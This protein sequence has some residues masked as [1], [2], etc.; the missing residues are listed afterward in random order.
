MEHEHVANLG[1]LPRQHADYQACLPEHEHKR[2]QRDDT[3]TREAR[4]VDAR[5]LATTT[6]Y[7]QIP[8]RDASLPPRRQR[9]F[10]RA[11]VRPLCSVPS[12][13]PVRPVR[14]VPRCRDHWIDLSAGGAPAR[15][16][17]ELPE[18]PD[19]RDC[20]PS[21]IWT[22]TASHL[23]QLRGVPDGQNRHWIAVPPPSLRYSSYCNG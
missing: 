20:L 16:S 23:G 3:A 18:A 12:R 1:C 13:P 2:R 9:C 11:C 14:L 5:S 10:A 21:P 19:P 8:S 17:L 4:C 7:T 22:C 6:R 15:S